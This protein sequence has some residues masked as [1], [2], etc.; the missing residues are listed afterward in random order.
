[1]LSAT[2]AGSNPAPREIEIDVLRIDDAIGTFEGADEV[3]DVGIGSRKQ[4][5]RYGSVGRELDEDDIGKETEAVVA[6][7]AGK[8]Q[9]R[10]QMLEDIAKAG[11]DIG[12][13]EARDGSDVAVEAREPHIRRNSEGPFIRRCR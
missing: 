12:R 1:L 5:E 9:R 11:V 3:T 7:L 13:R 2:R 8:H 6:D 10:I 4:P